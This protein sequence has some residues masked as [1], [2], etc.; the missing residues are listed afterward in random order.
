MSEWIPP[1]HRPHDGHPDDDVRWCECSGRCTQDVP[2]DCCEL[3]DLRA[4]EERLTAVLSGVRRVLAMSQ[5]GIVAELREQ[6]EAALSGEDEWTI[7]AEQRDR[8]IAAALDL[9]WPQHD[10]FDDRVIAGCGHCNKEWPCPTVQ[11]LRGES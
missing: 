8:R 6:I 3:A 9:H 7:E 1:G 11:A 10:A 5:T 2:C 4:E